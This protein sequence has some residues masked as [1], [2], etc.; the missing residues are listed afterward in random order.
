MR[1][2][3]ATMA[4]TDAGQI[5][6]GLEYPDQ[7][8]W[9]TD[10]AKLQADAEWQKIQGGL[11]GIRTV[12]SNAVWLDISPKTSQSGAG[13]TLVLMGAAVK[14][15]KLEGYRQRVGSV[16]AINERLKI[17]ARIR[18]W[19]A[20]LAGMAAGAV[21]IGIEYPDVP[22]YVAAQEKLAADAEW[23]KLLASLDE[24]RTLEGRWL[25]QEITP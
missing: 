4:G 1:V 18:M 17:P 15:G 24:L 23:Q 3:N 14:P 8:T 22:A 12:V 20:E 10:S 5:L 9:A 7:A 21:A 25:Y 19:Q 16:N 2:W 13:S 6:A 11:S